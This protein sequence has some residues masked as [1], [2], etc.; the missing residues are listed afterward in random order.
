MLVHVSTGNMSKHAQVL[1]IYMPIV[2]S[3]A[4]EQKFVIANIMHSWLSFIL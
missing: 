4:S 3:P 1:Y 2:E